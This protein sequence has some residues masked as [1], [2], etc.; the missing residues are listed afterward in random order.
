MIP[1]IYVRCYLVSQLAGMGKQYIEVL[2]V[3]QVP[4]FHVLNVL[5]APLAVN[6]D[7]CPWSLTTTRT[8]KVFY[9]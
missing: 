2:E 4:N 3:H 5:Y 7:E 6:K 8:Y 9:T 1:V